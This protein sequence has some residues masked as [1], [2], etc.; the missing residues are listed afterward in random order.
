LGDEFVK[1]LALLGPHTAPLGIHFYT[2]TAF[3]SEYRGQAFIARHGSWNKSKKIGGDIVVAK[4]NKDGTVKSLDTFITGFLDNN[5]Y[6]GRP[7]D[8]LV[9]KDGSLLI[10]DDYN[11]AVYRVSYGNSVAAH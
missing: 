7:V 8:L 11:G 5:N 1:P 9:M 6:V 3:P 4:L 2:G 10:S